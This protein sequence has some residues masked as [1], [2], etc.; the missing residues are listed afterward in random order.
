LEPTWKEAAD[1]GNRW[2]TK[3]S[4]LKAFRDLSGRSFRDEQSL[5]I[6]VSLLTQ[7]HN[8]SFP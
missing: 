1:Y 2:V 7:V 3:A 4:I 6:R 5:P 8:S